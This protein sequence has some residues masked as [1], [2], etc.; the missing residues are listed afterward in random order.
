M[1][2]R[3]YYQRA[4]K[5]L[6]AAFKHDVSPS[7]GQATST[8]Q[9]KHARLSVYEFTVKGRLEGSAAAECSRFQFSVFQRSAPRVFRL[10]YATQANALEPLW[11]LASAA[12]ELVVEALDEDGRCVAY[13]TVPLAKTG[14]NV[15]V[16]FHAGTG[17]VKFIDEKRVINDDRVLA[18]LTAE[19]IVRPD[20]AEAT[21]QYPEY[22]CIPISEANPAVKISQFKLKVRDL[23]IT[24]PRAKPGSAAADY[25]AT[26]LVHNG[27]KELAGQTRP[28]VPLAL[29]AGAA[30]PVAH[31]PADHVDEL[32]V[33][34]LASSHL[35][36][37]VSQGGKPI[38][39]AA[40]P[41]VG[42]ETS[43]VNVQIKSLPLL[44]GPY[45]CG[46]VRVASPPPR[47]VGSPRSLGTPSA[48]PPSTMGPRAPR[49]A[50]R[51]RWPKPRA[52][53]RPTRGHATPDPRPCTKRRGQRSPKCCPPPS[54]PCWNKLPLHRR[55]ALRPL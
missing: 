36:I 9:P 3:S 28:S 8:L 31:W 12:D 50:S 52:N 16:Q 54:S 17:A 14:A 42:P 34:L 44:D 55:K 49:R 7:T 24:A 43:D 30:V 2:T 6:S 1:A 23:E 26:V 46:E 18:Q 11:F 5:F 39:V 47:A 13:A 53:S 33:P 10:P 35:V 32:S 29:R 48:S 21:K 27:Y 20:P 19:L 25:S 37:V 22:V 45:S 41:L 51:L 40:Y 15:N 4:R 38:G